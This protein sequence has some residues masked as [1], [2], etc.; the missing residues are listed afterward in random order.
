MISCQQSPRDHLPSLSETSDGE[1]KR[2][3]TTCSEEYHCECFVSLLLLLA[4]SY[5]NSVLVIGRRFL[6]SLH[7]GR[8]WSI[9]LVLLQYRNTKWSI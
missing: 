7:E 3:K 9:E 5:N 4:G 6:F 2:T 8:Y 1:R